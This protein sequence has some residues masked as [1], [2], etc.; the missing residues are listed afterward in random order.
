MLH[1]HWTTGRFQDCSMPSVQKWL[2]GN[3][4]L[5]SCY[6][7]ATVSFALL[8][9]DR[10][11]SFPVDVR[12]LF[13]LQIVQSHLA[14]IIM[15]KRHIQRRNNVTKVRVEPE[16][17]DQGC[18]KKDIFTISAS[19]AY[20]WTKNLF[21]FS[22]S[23]KKNHLTFWL[24]ITSTAGACKETYGLQI[25]QHPEYSSNYCSSGSAYAKRTKFTFVCSCFAWITMFAS[26]DL[27]LEQFTNPRTIPVQGLDLNYHA[28]RT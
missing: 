26:I 13:S 5:F 20:N 24:C 15:V 17:C 25:K 9:V 22:N 8:G 3:A 27:E 2:I 19:L 18:R 1:H 23:D 4:Y 28:G 21:Y 10:F 6:E 14:E 16:S 11:T 12:L 7:K